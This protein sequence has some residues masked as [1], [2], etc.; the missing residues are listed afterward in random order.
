MGDVGLA[1]V[2][3]G[4]WARTLADAAGR[5]GGLAVRGGFARTE[6]SRRAFADRF[7][8]RAFG[9][10][11][12]ALAAADVDGVIVATPHS[13]H[14]DVIVAA[15]QA[16]KHVF[17]E[18]PLSN[19]FASARTAVEAAE[20][21]GIVLQVGQNHRRQAGVRHLKRIVESEDLGLI[22]LVEGV[23]SKPTAFV[24][25]PPWRLDPEEAP[26]GG[27][28]GL[29]V[30]YVDNFHYLLG[31]VRRVSAYSKRLHGA[32][33]KDDITVLMMEF[34]S[35][36][37]GYLAT[38][39]AIPEIRSLSVHGTLGS[40]WLQQPGG[41]AYLAQTGEQVFRQGVD[42]DVRVLEEGA[43]Q[44]TDPLAEQLAEFRDL[45]QA[46]G[47][48]PEVGGREGLAVVAVLEAAVLSVERGASVELAELY[49]S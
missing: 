32:S 38:S 22:H 48:R 8:G 20:A 34:E 4:S 1:F 9:S 40:V 18:K 25:R 16:G 15:A 13:A 47:G 39:Q 42:D 43:L 49:A 41:A 36:P 2:G 30:H 21:A 5:A 27:M 19:R 35:G 7:G 46:G 23:L 12:E 11:E 45:V 6:E 28:T 10:L 14:T 33:D 29:G 24:N 17:V 26:L 44:P 3:L 31:D 37:L